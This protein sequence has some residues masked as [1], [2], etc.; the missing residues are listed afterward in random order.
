[1]CAARLGAG[2]RGEEVLGEK[3]GLRMLAAVSNSGCEFL[4]RRSLDKTEMARK[5][6]KLEI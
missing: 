2:V 4:S 3:R 6:L 1:M 5:K